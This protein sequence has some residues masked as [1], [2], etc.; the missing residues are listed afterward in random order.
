[1]RKSIWGTTAVLAAAAAWMAVSCEEGPLEPPGP[2]PWDYYGIK[3]LNE[4]KVVGDIHM[5][6][7]TE[8]WA[9]TDGGYVLR[10]DGTEWRVHTDFSQKYEG[11]DITRLSFC[12]PEEGWALGH[13]YVGA[14]EYE[15]YILRY[16]GLH[17]SRVT[18]I[19]D[20]LKKCYRLREYDVAALAP[21]DVWV[22][23]Y[24]DV[25]H[26]DGQT[27]E[28][29]RLGGSHSL[30]FSSPS[31]GWAIGYGPRYRWNGSEW[32][33]TYGGYDPVSDV[34]CPSQD[35]AWAVGGFPGG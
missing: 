17:W 24:F 20:A 26:Y 14:G 32:Q 35:S 3:G 2:V 34:A 15:L 6:S 23:N 9:V 16:D 19:P 13:R 4:R 29:Y 31:N 18:A 7:A 5:V 28:E 25:F 30:S 33:R 12:A 1:M 11:I 21:D 10:F 8:G 27:W 22:T